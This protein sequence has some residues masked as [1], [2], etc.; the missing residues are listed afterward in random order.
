MSKIEG[1]TEGLRDLPQI[2]K[3]INRAWQMWRGMAQGRQAVRVE[4]RASQQE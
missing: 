4:Q 1:E 3:P 2:E